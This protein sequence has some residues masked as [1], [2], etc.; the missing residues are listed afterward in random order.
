MKKVKIFFS[1]IFV[2]LVIL[3]SRPSYAMS[4]S[5][6]SL[7]FDIKILENGSVS[8]T[9]IWDTYLND[10][11][12][13]YKTFN[14]GLKSKKIEDVS[15]SELLEVQG[16]TIMK[17]FT[18]SGTY[19]YHEQKKYF[20]AT[21]NKWGNFEIA[22]G[23][24]A[25][26]IE[27]RTFQ[28]EYTICDCIN[29]YN[30]C[31][32]FYWQLIGNKWDIETH[33]IY[34]TVTL[35]SEITN[36]E[37]FR[38]WGHGPLEG[39]IYKKGNNS[40]FFFVR[41]L[42]KKTFLELRLVFPKSVVKDST[43]IINKDKFNKILKEEEKNA[44]KDIKEETKNKINL[45]MIMVVYIIISGIF[46]ITDLIKINKIKKEIKN[47][48][49]YKGKANYEYFRDIPN[50]KMDPVE[51]TL[52]AFNDI[53]DENMITSLI[54]SLAYKKAITIKSANKPKDTEI[55]LN[56]YED[57]NYSRYLTTAEKYLASYFKEIGNRFSI[58]ELEKYIIKNES[59][60]NLLLTIIRSSSNS[61]LW[62]NFYC[63]IDKDIYK[64]IKE[65]NFQKYILNIFRMIYIY[66]SGAI[67][68][69]SS[70]YNGGLLFIYGFTISLVLVLLFYIISAIYTSKLIK[71]VNIYTESG[72]E[73]RAKWRGLKHFLEDFSLIDER[74]IPEI[75][76]WEQ[77]L[78]YATGFGIAN[79]VLKQLKTRFP[80]LSSQEFF[81]HHSCFYIANNHSIHKSISSTVNHVTK[82]SIS[83]HGGGFSSGGGGGRRRR[84]VAVEDKITFLSKKIET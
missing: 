16:V 76:L 7:D 61:N 39:V 46:I 41:R 40:C 4:Q 68:M 34:G 60:F 14:K 55:I 54:M 75:E 19:N 36:D 30:D 26:G 27:R 62:N 74:E 37:D 6:F 57:S 10:T 42:P 47:I 80:E 44:T 50:N 15:V 8:V 3:I 56:L 12:T 31:A 11:N 69:I 29:V 21:K 78:V 22:W 73:E 64:N 33:D 20:H 52:L 82:L 24:S 81:T 65:I 63:Y 9:E 1:F 25:T 2:F 43:N 49:F 51:A 35:P 70:T 72:T 5:L 83:G 38:V 84:P 77:Y 67:I 32:E 28:I 18:N 79:K 13:L 58:K 23:V 66:L 59:S 45:Y 17:P 48:S 71:G 53:S